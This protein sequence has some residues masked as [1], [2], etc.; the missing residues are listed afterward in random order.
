VSRLRHTLAG[1]VVALVFLVVAATAVSALVILG[2]L[3][4]LQ[5]G[6]DRLTEVYV[7]FNHELA[8]AQV[9]AVRIGEQVRT[10]QYQAEHGGPALAPP[11]DAAF[12]RNFSAALEE[13]RARVTAARDPID[14]ALEEPERYG[15]SEQLVELQEIQVSLDRLDGL[16]AGDHVRDP[17][18]VLV[19][20]R[21]QRQIEQLLESLAAQ[22]QHAVDSLREEL[23]GTRERTALLTL[24]LSACVAALG[25]LAAVGV[26]WTLR[27]LRQLT[28]GVRNLARGDWSQR[29]RMPG[30]RDDEVRQLGAEFNS[31]A[32][33]LEER[34]RRLLRGERLAAAGQLAAQITHEIRN[35]LSA[36]QLNAELLGDELA[37]ASPEARELLGKI[38]K[39]VDR[40]SAITDDYLRFARHP[41]PELAR[42]EL[43]AELES[44]I[45]FMRPQM[46]KAGVA[47][48]LELPADAVYVAGDRNQLRQAFMNLVRNAQEA[49]VGEETVPDAAPAVGVRMWC[50]DD[51]VFVVVS[52]NG[53]G[54][55][56]PAE[57]IERIFEAFF[58]R[59]AKGTGLGLPTVQ[60]IVHDHG[61]TV[62][63]AETGPDGTRFE[64][65]LPACDPLDP[66][67]SSPS[68]RASAHDD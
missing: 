29:I 36:V 24:A 2:Q 55:D 43:R 68:I 66:S 42:L 38:S 1:R 44:L 16:V 14:D 56:L 67:V 18:E 57:D 30:D 35:P 61:G 45:D 13:R 54:I 37:H 51:R 49:A 40:L 20:V 48:Q 32:E 3:R 6:L 60:Q 25:G 47:V 26:V 9:Q 41:K 11:P 39:E 15:G 12:L 7:V 8:A 59:K 23:R 65:C 21:S 64:V 53:P 33:A 52:D 5:H 62:R 17:E 34:E 46:A 10:R 50:K 28:D 27:P 63:V 19:D 31:M 4:A 22:S 58:T